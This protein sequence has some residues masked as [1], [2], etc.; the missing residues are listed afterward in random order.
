MKKI[1]DELISWLQNLDDYA[2]PDYSYFPSIDLYMDQVITFLEKQLQLLKIDDNPILTSSMVN[3][4]VKADLLEPPEAKKYKTHHLINL[5]SICYVKQIL[6]ISDI[7]FIFSYLVK[8]ETQSK[9][10]YQILQHTY[11]NKIKDIQNDYLKKINQINLYNSTND[12]QIAANLLQLAYD[13]SLEA[14]FKKIVAAKIISLTK[15]YDNKLDD[16]KSLKEIKKE[17]KKENKKNEK[18]E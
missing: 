4:Y 16:K 12:E 9:K 8:D 17:Q 10:F 2:L 14:E 15:N 11:Q 5:L 18:K 3:N 6:S 1:I 13:L 7:K